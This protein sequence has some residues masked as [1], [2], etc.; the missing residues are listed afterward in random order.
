[1]ERKMIYV[2]TKYGD[3]KIEYSDKKWGSIVSQLSNGMPW[4]AAGEYLFRAD[5]IVLIKEI[6]K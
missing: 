1:M 5:D 4:I 2:E 6:A 3:Y